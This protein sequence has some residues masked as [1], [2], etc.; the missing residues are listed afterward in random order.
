[1]YQK[2]YKQIKDNYRRLGFMDKFILWLEFKTKPTDKLLNLIPR[3]GK[4]LDLGQQTGKIDKDMLDR[5]TEEVNNDLAIPQALALTW[6]VFKTDFPDAD[7]RATLIEF[8][9]VL[10]LGLEKIK[11]QDVIIPDEIKKLVEARDKARASQSWKKS[12]EL[13]KKIED[14]GWLLE[15]TADTSRLKKK[16]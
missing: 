11:Q 5:F 4:F 2:K 12:D 9:K 6:E 13:R 10:G 15:D 1:M 3:K 16:D 7:K 8:D 14:K